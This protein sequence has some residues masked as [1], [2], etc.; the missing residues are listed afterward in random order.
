M[1][2]IKCA[3]LKKKEKKKHSFEGTRFYRSS[4]AETAGKRFVRTD[5]ETKVFTR[6]TGSFFSRR[7]LL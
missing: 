4:S 6:G 3:N 2:R 5:E 1:R 7:K